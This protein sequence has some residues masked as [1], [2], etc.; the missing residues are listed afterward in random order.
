MNGDILQCMREA[1]QYAI[2]MK[3]LWIDFDSSRKYVVEAIDKLKEEGWITV[4][5]SQYKIIVKG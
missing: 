1:L 3:G 4:K 2:D 5:N